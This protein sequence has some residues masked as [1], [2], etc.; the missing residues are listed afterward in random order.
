M[1]KFS[2]TNVQLR[3]IQFEIAVVV[4]SDDWQRFLSLEQVDILMDIE[5]HRLTS[6]FTHLRKQDKLS[7][8]Q[9]LL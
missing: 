1:Q 2:L 3:N 5:F 7:N 8:K 9:N 6:T 4:T